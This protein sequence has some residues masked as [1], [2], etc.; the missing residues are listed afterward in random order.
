MKKKGKRSR[1]SNMDKLLI[2]PKTEGREISFHG[3]MKYE[4][5]DTKQCAV[6]EASCGAPKAQPP[7]DA[8]TNLI[9]MWFNALQTNDARMKYRA[10]IPWIQ[11]RS[12]TPNTM[13]QCMIMPIMNEKMT[14]A[15]NN[16]H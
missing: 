11:I 9:A 3:K 6:K 14:K 12:M 8:A 2:Q 13:K 16:S 15:K 4:K 5:S 10:T 1:K 7:Y